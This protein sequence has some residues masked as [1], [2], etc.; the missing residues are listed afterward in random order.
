[1]LVLRPDDGVAMTLAG[2]ETRD[3]V[4]GDRTAA[5]RAHDPPV[6]ARVAGDRTV[7]DLRSVDPADDPVLAKALSA[8]AAASG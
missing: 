7:A 8:A 5:L 3:L 6:I 1:M 2:E 4:A